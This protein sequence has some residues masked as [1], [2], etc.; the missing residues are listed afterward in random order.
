MHHDIQK[1]FSYHNFYLFFPICKRKEFELFQLLE[2]FKKK[3]ANAPSIYEAR[4]WISP[5]DL[6]IPVDPEGMKYPGGLGGLGGPGDPR[7]PGCLGGPGGP[8]SPKCHGFL[9]STRG[10]R[11]L[12]FLE[13][14][15]GPEDLEGMSM[16]FKMFLICKGQKVR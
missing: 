15:G 9:G 7:S 4:P 11:G 10:L 16:K 3:S 12:V 2:S 8:G 13:D 1:V 5:D 6:G 14:P